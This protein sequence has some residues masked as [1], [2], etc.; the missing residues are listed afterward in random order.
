MSFFK[1]LRERPTQKMDSLL[2]IREAPLWTSID[3]DASD[4]SVLEAVCDA[5][6]WFLPF[7]RGAPSVDETIVEVFTQRVTKGL[8]AF[9]QFFQM[10]LPVKNNLR[11]SISWLHEKVPSL[12]SMNSVPHSFAVRAAYIS[13]L[14]HEPAKIGS[15][16]PK[17][18]KED[19][20]F[21]QKVAALVGLKDATDKSWKGHL[22]HAYTKHRQQKLVQLMDDLSVVSLPT[23]AVT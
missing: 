12:A 17:Y 7:S 15:I 8:H 21:V 14:L 18:K 5:L 6:L 3:L 13:L 4:E 22:V 19:P 20:L 2:Y 23:Q 11:D 16:G 1:D 9:A 10:D